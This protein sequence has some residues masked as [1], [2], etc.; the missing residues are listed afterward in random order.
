ML[1]PCATRLPRLLPPFPG[2]LRRVLPPATAP[3]TRQESLEF[4]KRLLTPLYMAAILDPRTTLKEV[5]V[6]AFHDLDPNLK[7]YI[8]PGPSRRTKPARP[9]VPV[10]PVPPELIKYHDIERR[11]ARHGRFRDRTGEVLFNRK[12]IG[13]AGFLL[14]P[15]LSSRHMFDSTNTGP[16]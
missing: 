10:C 2:A 8:V 15:F 5:S 7:R 13:L 9:V 4:E 6:M 1:P 14:I 11:T 12:C 16:R 3:T